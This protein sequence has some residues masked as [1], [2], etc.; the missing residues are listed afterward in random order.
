MAIF[1]IKLGTLGGFMKCV[2]QIC[3]L[4]PTWRMAGSV[5]QSGARSGK[6]RSESPPR[7]QM[8]FNNFLIFCNS[9]IPRKVFKSQVGK[10]NIVF[11]FSIHTP[12]E[13]TQIACEIIFFVLRSQWILNASIIGSIIRHYCV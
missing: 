9:R 13:H 8:G 6:R 4:K 10:F 2:N 12:F 3:I 7:R 11:L 5:V 1:A